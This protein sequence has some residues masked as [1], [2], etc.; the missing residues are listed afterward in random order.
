MNTMMIG[1]CY[2]NIANEFIT[3]LF[4]KLPDLICLLK[5]E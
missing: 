5:N 4:L 1:V 2:K 3:I